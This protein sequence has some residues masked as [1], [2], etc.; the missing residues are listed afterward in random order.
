M[1]I[2]IYIHS[3]SFMGAVMVVI[4][5]GFTYKCMQSVPITTNMSLNPVQAMQHY[6]IKLVSDLRQV[7][8]FLRVL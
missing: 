7:C 1:F 3:Y 5:V 6:V 8:G 2:Y 4:V